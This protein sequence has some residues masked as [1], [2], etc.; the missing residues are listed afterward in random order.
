MTNSFWGKALQSIWIVRVCA[1]L[2]SEVQRKKL[3]N[4]KSEGGNSSLL[5]NE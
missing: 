5:R 2:I 3:I 1:L 4:E